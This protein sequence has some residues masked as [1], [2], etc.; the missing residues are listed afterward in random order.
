MTIKQHHQLYIYHRNISTKYH[1]GKPHWPDRWRWDESAMCSACNF[2]SNFVNGQMST[3]WSAVV[4]IHQM[5][6]WQS[7]ICADLQGLWPTWKWFSRRWDRQT[8]IQPQGL[9]MEWLK[10]SNDVNTRNDK[11]NT[12]TNHHKSP[13][14]P[15]WHKRHVLDNTQSDWI[16]AQSNY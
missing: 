2:L 9:A 14:L 10:H 8:Y 6:V 3:M 16:N 1:V 11:T 5:L 7:P 15:Q 13:A 12:Q 4:R